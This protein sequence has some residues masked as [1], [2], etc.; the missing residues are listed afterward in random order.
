M[1][2]LFTWAQLWQLRFNVKKC[3]TLHY[4]RNNEKYEYTLNFEDIETAS[5]ETD[6]GVTFQDLKFSSHIAEK[7][8]K[9][10]STLS[11]IV[12]TFDYIE[13]DSFILLYK[14]LIRPHIEYGN[15]IWHPF[16]RKD[17]ESIE[18]VQKRATKLVPELKDLTYIER[19]K[20]E[21]A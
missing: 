18:K 1:D 9:A 20:F 10:N 15:V 6:L 5:E 17:I 19:L 12:R 3:K 8:N 21:T 7:V 13:K 11:V 2:A 14:A 4:G 16:L